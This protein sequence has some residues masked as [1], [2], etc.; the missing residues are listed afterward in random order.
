MGSL[1]FG[2]IGH[3]CAMMSIIDAAEVVPADVVADQDQ[4]RVRIGSHPDPVMTGILCE[5]RL[6]VVFG[7]R[8]CRER[9][10]QEGQKSLKCPAEVIHI[11]RIVS[12]GARYLS[13]FPMQETGVGRI[14]DEESI[15]NRICVR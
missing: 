1:L 9:Q 10:E 12:F 4:I 13:H 3:A 8:P 14:P 7:K 5:R 2:W 6:L 11:S 15:E